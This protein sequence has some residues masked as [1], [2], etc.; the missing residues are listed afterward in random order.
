MKY[1]FTKKEI[2]RQQKINGIK[3][4]VCSK[5]LPMFKKAIKILTALEVL[6]NQKYSY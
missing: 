6:T 3:T 5:P 2:Q 4:D 1:Y